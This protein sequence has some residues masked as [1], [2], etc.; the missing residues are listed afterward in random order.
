M[1]YRTARTAS[2]ALGA[3]VVLGAALRIYSWIGNPSLWI[4]E[5]ALARNIIDRGFHGL[6]APLDAQQVAAPGFLWLEKLAITLFGTGERAL[7]LVPLLASLASL[8]LFALIARRL[9]RPIAA[10]FALSLFATATP[11][12]FYASETKQYSLDVA[13]ALALFLLAIRAR[14]GGSDVG[15][16]GDRHGPLGSRLTGLAVLGTIAPWFSQPSVFA[17][18][19]V[20]LYLAIPFFRARGAA[21]RRATLRRLLPLFALWAIG[22]GASIARSIMQMDP[23]TRAALDNYWSH[24]FMPLG[25]GI[26]ASATWLG[27][28]THD[29]FAWLFP[30][31]AATITVALFVLG[32]AALIRRADG[33]ASL[34]LAPLAF[35]LLASV[36]RLYPV[37]YRLL[38][39]TAPSLLIAVGAGA[40]ALL[41]LARAPFE[42]KAGVRGHGARADGGGAFA[43]AALVT[44][45][46]CAGLALVAI[47]SA[48]AMVEIPF[49]R[50]ELRPLVSYLAEHRRADDTIY[51][52]Y[53]ASP[54]F[55]YY[56]ARDGI[57]ASAYRLGSCERD[58]WRAYLSE[59]NEL[60]ER[61]RVWFVMSHGFRKAGIQEDSLF[62]RYFA[63]LGSTTD[64]VSAVGAELRLYDLAAPAA[65]PG[66][67][68][69]V[70]PLSG[71]SSL[72]RIG[73]SGAVSE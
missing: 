37:S 24:G 35:M 56:A 55:Q 29:V 67:A 2:I 14:G 43:P 64:S 40:E 1:V 12:L 68:N 30:P 70:P 69:F 27:G 71:D 17:L 3:L 7:R 49:Y 62:F 5:A 13:I 4:D 19:G 28:T 48:M 39:F 32:I 57:P 58:D 65:L 72:A 8:P 44:I 42:W 59:M 31:I 15:A 47:R 36:L 53:G 52:Y 20:G 11:L 33:S 22:G 51:V 18:G 38:L 6:L 73:C 25:S 26:V 9:L 34:L 46:I 23:T 60:R 50:E 21:E 66:S 63:T 45:V 10:T 16:R 54:A 41:A 61:P